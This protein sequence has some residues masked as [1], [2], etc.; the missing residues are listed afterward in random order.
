MIEV[1]G[2]LDKSNTQLKFSGVIFRS[3][4]FHLLRREEVREDEIKLNEISHI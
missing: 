4:L 3:A 2:K 1:S